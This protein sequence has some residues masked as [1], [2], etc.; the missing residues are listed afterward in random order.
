MKKCCRNHDVL[1]YVKIVKNL[2]TK[3]LALLA[4]KNISLE[5]NETKIIYS[6]ISRIFY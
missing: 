3:R 4:E 5:K 6:I 2:K 1:Y